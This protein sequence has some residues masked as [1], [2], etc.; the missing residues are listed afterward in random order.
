MAVKP[1]Q[2]LRELWTL[3]RF[4]GR[5]MSVYAE[6]MMFV[7]ASKGIRTLGLVS[8]TLLSISALAYS[9]LGYDEIYVHSSVVL[10][11]LSLHVAISARAARETKALYLLGTTL[12]L[13]SGVAF[14]LLAHYS[15]SL[16]AALF[17]GVML[18]FLL[19]PLVPWGLREAMLIVVLVYSMFTL[20]TLSVEDRFETKTLWMLQ[21]MMFAG[22]ITT[23]IVVAR[24]ALIRR[25]DIRTRYE[26]EQAHDRMELLS[27]V[28][29]LTGAWNRRFLEQRFDRIRKAARDTGEGLQFALIDIDNFKQINDSCGHDYG[30]AVLRRLVANF[31]CVMQGTD[32]L[33]RVGGDEFL[34]LMSHADAVAR[35]TMAL[36]ALA[37][38]PEV[39]GCADHAIDRVEVSIG[40]V[41]E[42]GQAGSL[43]ALYRAAD[44]ALY[45]SKAEKHL[46]NRERIKVDRMEEEP[47]ASVA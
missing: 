9:I 21:L 37:R 29:P 17:A 44:Q 34:L 7:D 28:D 42:D 35:I 43:D 5:E 4:E 46:P 15:H 31:R 32:H 14:V 23:L 3:T 1:L 11:V 30:D 12:V 19:M 26:L 18:L 47:S 10:A 40:M 41:M 27:F 16:N 45:R 2:T 22:S 6:S 36:D 13:V 8:M 33:V 39:R 38:D 24:H 25:N 20:S